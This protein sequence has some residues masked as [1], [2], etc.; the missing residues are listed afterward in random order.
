MA[1]DKKKNKMVADDIIRGE[2]VLYNFQLYKDKILDQ[3][4]DGHKETII[5]IACTLKHLDKLSSGAVKNLYSYFVELSPSLRMFLWSEVTGDNI[6]LDVRCLIVN[7][8]AY[9]IIKQLK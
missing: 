9:D 5:R 4:E 8:I 2:D 6:N 1:V 7:K 3:D